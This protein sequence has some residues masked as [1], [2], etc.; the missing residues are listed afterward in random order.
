M[1]DPQ[2]GARPKPTNTALMIAVLSGVLAI[3]PAVVIGM[4]L[5]DVPPFRA[6]LEARVCA[7]GETIVFRLR[8][9]GSGRSQTVHCRAVDGQIGDADVG[10]AM[11]WAATRMV[12]TPLTIVIALVWW[13]VVLTRRGREARGGGALRASPAPTVRRVE[14]TSSPSITRTTDEVTLVLGDEHA[15]MVERLVSSERP[16]LDDVQSLLGSLRESGLLPTEALAHGRVV[17]LSEGDDVAGSLRRLR[18]LR[19]QGLISL[20]EFE[21]RRKAVLERI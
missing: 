5:V 13:A 9:T 19:D 1:E 15:E 2:R 3:V 6:A 17:D 10:L 14:E 11:M 16:R 21:E 18:A 4:M 7:P 20:A 8:M 12:W